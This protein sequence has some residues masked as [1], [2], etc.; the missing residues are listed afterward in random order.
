MFC[1]GKDCK[2]HQFRPCC[3]L[4][5]WFYRTVNVPCF[6]PCPDLLVPQTDKEQ[7]LFRLALFFLGSCVYVVCGFFLLTL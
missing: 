6:C 3:H 7:E 1:V 4:Q 2:D 5:A